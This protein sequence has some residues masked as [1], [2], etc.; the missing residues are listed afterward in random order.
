MITLHL[1]ASRFM[2]F[3]EEQ[4]DLGM[5]GTLDDRGAFP[6]YMGKYNL[7][8][9]VHCL[10]RGA[11]FGSTR[12]N[13]MISGVVYSEF[14]SVEFVGRANFHLLRRTAYLVHQFLV[15]SIIT[16]KHPHLL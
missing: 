7:M 1:R 3:A 10:K 4:C 8:I 16:A 14:R 12:N 11:L 2:S 15:S 13:C 5:S 9:Q 6:S